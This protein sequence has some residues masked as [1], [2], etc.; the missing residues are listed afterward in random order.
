MIARERK[1]KSQLFIATHSTDILDGLIAG[2]ASKVRI[3]R[4][5][6]D[7]AVNRVKELSREKTAAISN[8]TLAR[9]SGVFGGIF[10][11]HVVICESDSD[12]LFYS[13]ILNTKTVS[14]EQRADILFI[15]TSGKHRM[16]QLAETLRELD[17][18]VSVVADVDLFNEE[19][20]FRKLF[21]SL[22][23]DWTQVQSEWKA[24]KTAVEARKPPLNAEQVAGMIKNE[25]EGITGT[26]PFPKE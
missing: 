7:G 20:T 18:P 8:D 14:G 26:S 2:G 5:Q 1:A 25:L 24:L 15:H 22:D 9:Y 11:Q 16:G 13:S 6:R 12:C 3:V 21:E 19:E 17:V 4:I 10:Y 23:G